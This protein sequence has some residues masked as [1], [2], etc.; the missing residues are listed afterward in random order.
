MLE[1]TEIR[2]RKLTHRN[3]TSNLRKSYSSNQHIVQATCAGENELQSLVL[4]AEASP[5]I[6]RAGLVVPLD[7]S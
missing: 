3:E 1:I 6:P 7:R 2:K 5:L 4:T